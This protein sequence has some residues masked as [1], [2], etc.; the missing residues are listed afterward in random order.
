MFFSLSRA[1]I[2]SIA[3]MRSMRSS[4]EIGSAVASSVKGA[5]NFAAG[6]ISIQRCAVTQEK[7]ALMRSSRLRLVTG[8]PAQ[9]SRKVRA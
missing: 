2:R 6:L 3:P 7:N 5:F 4:R 1:G 8:E 9:D